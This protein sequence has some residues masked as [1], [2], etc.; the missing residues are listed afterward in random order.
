MRKILAALLTTAALTAAAAQASPAQAAC[1]NWQPDTSDA[2][3]QDNGWNMALEYGADGYWRAYAM[4]PGSDGMLGEVTFSRWSANDIRFTIT[5]RNGS[6]GRYAG[7]IDSSGFIGGIARDV[8]N[9]RAWT[10]WRMR[11]IAHCAG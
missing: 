3:Y 6:A 2:I 10:K 11:D 8:H 5:W 9:T 1:S 7:H 4:N